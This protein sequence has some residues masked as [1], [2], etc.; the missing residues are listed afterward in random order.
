MGNW[1]CF[2]LDQTNEAENGE[3]KKKS[4]EGYKKQKKQEEGPQGMEEICRPRW[5]EFGEDEEKRKEEE[6]QKSGEEELEEVLLLFFWA[7]DAGR[8]ERAL[9]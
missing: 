6:R 9:M 1:V 8:V 3:G 7:T 2:L 5:S 4:G